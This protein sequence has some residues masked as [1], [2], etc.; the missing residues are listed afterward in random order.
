MCAHGD[1]IGLLALGDRTE[2]LAGAARGYDRLCVVES[3]YELPGRLPC[4]LRFGS[5]IIEDLR[6]T[7]PGMNGETFLDRYRNHKP[8]GWRQ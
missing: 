1:E 4:C 5:Q 3:G 7:H 8:S 2:D 6:R